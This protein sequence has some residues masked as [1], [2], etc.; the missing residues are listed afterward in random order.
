[1]SRDAIKMGLTDCT[2]ILMYDGSMISAKLRTLK[3]CLE[4]VVSEVCFVDMTGLLIQCVRS[5]KFAFSALH[6]TAY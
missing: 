3:L 5:C 1:M 2:S 4:I 6:S